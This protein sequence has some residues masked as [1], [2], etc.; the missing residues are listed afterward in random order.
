MVDELEELAGGEV[1]GDVGRAVSIDT[2][3]GVATGATLQA[4][5]AILGEGVQVGLVHVEVLAL[6]RG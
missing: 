2:D 3:D 6:Q 1:P 5:T 4:P